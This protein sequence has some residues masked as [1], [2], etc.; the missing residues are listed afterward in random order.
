MHLVPEV[1]GHLL[2][3]LGLEH[4]PGELFEKPIRFGQRHTR[5][6]GQ[7]PAPLQPAALPAVRPPLSV[8]SLLA[9]ATDVPAEQH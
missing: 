6:P 3:Q 1:I 7:S 8:A 5:V 4:R 2:A 9:D